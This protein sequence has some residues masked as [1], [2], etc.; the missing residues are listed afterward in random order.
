MFQRFICDS[1]RSW[2]LLLLQLFQRFFKLPEGQAFSHT[3]DKASSSCVL[4]HSLCLGPVIFNS[5]SWGWSCALFFKNSGKDVCCRLSRDS[6]ICG[7][8]CCSAPLWVV[9]IQWP[10]GATRGVT[11]SISAFLACHQCY[12]VGSSLAWGLNLR[13]VVCGIFWSSSSGVFSRYSGFLP[14]FIGLMVQP[15]KVSSNKCDYNSVKLNSWAV[16][17]YQ[18]ARNMTLAR[19]KHS[20]C[21]T[22]FAHGCARATWEYVWDSSQP[23]EED[24][25]R[26]QSH[27]LGTSEAEGPAPFHPGCGPPGRH[28]NDPK[29]TALPCYRWYGDN[30]FSVH[31][32]LAVSSDFGGWGFSSGWPPPQGQLLYRAGRSIL[33]RF[34]FCISIA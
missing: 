21:C 8:Q 15:I 16:P 11:V 17:S 1:I 29:I 26:S 22:W 24:Q 3:W 12:C 10:F 25:S 23:S 30:R 7:L 34:V 19:D 13:D 20:M 4:E 14:S 31:T 32:K 2:S 18:V 33:P 28:H 5:I 9:S 6:F 27:W